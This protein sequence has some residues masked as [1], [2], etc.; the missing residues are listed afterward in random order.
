MAIGTIEN[1]DNGSGAGHVRVYGYDANCSNWIQIGEDID[2]EAAHDEFGY[3][4][5]LSANGN[6]VA[7]G[8]AEND[9]NCSKA[10]HVR[11]NAGLVRVFGFGLP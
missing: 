8:A 2:A 6:I 7:I 3:S 5:S 4:V 10:G 9:G 11:S 1:D